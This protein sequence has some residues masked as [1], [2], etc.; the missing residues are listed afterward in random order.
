MT[1]TGERR[2]R[3]APKKGPDILHLDRQNASEGLKQNPGR[4]P[5]RKV[6]QKHPRKSR[7]EGP[8]KKKRRAGQGLGFYS[9]ATV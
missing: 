3:R 6:D 8:G 1:Q 9:S 2:D 5:V 7:H 4:R